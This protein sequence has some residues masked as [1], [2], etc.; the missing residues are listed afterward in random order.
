TRVCRALRPN[1]SLNG[2]NMSG[3]RIILMSG[4]AVLLALGTAQAQTTVTVHKH[5][6]H[7]ENVLITINIAPVAE[8]GGISGGAMAASASSPSASDANAGLEARVR[9]LEEQ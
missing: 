4:A 2:E 7:H 9:R 8:N 6:R 5:K 3:K 1:A